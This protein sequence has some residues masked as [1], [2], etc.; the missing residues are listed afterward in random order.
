MTPLTA[1]F[2]PEHVAWLGAAIRVR[3]DAARIAIPRHDV[4]AVVPLS[5]V[6][7]V[8]FAFGRRR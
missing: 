6:F 1:G 4:L 8:T 3:T 7:G 2:E 5:Y